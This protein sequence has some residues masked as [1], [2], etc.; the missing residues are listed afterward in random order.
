MMQQMCVCVQV[1]LPPPKPLTPQLQQQQLKVLP[2]LG[3][4]CLCMTLRKYDIFN[5]RDC[6]KKTRDTADGLQ[7]VSELALQNAR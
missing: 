5:S 3:Y 2:N 7:R 4:A 6:V 1:V